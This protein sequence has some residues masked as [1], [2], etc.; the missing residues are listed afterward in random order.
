MNA[1]WQVRSMLK[2]C[3]LTFVWFPFQSSLD[4]GRF[5]TSSEAVLELS[6]HRLFCVL[7][8]AFTTR[9]SVAD[10]NLIYNLS[11]PL[12][13]FGC[14][15]TKLLDNSFVE[16]TV[17]LSG[18][19]SFSGLKLF[20]TL[21]LRSPS[22]YRMFSK[23]EQFHGPVIKLYFTTSLATGNKPS[24]LNVQCNTITCIIWGYRWR[25]LVF[26]I[27]LHAEYAWL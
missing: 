6:C 7:C 5:Q 11:E 27:V 18:K 26:Y 12:W 10:L 20:C 22:Q 21:T 24:K 9:S 25:F 19:L 3:N 1:Q 4:M 15:I 13:F 23:W 8:N 2:W 14:Q 16:N 17:K